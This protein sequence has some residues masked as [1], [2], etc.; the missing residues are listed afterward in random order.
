MGAEGIGIHG[1]GGP[2]PAGTR[3]QAR[4]PRPRRYRSRAGLRQFVDRR[5][6]LVVFDRERD[7]WIRIS[8]A[9]GQIVWARLARPVREADLWQQ[10]AGLFPHVDPARIQQDVR[11]FI[12][13]LAAMDLI[14]GPGRAKAA[15]E[16]SLDEHGGKA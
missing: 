3:R 13:R 7:L 9:V 1:Q 6:V 10:V 12:V 5:G 15:S 14:V 8:S 4:N 11:S 16:R 2:S